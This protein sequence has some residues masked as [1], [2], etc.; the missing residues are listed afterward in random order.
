MFECGES[1]LSFNRCL[2]QG[3]VSKLPHYGRRSPCSCWLTCKK[4]GQG[5]EWASFVTWERKEHIR[6]AISCDNFWIMSRKSLGTDVAG[7]ELLC[8]DLPHRV[9]E[10]KK[11]R[12]L[13]AVFEVMA[14]L[15]GDVE[16]LE[17][18]D[19]DTPMEHVSKQIKVGTDRDGI[20][21]GSPNKIDDL[22]KSTTEDPLGRLE[23]KRR[24]VTV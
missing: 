2:R 18:V 24:L 15:A 8:S 19:D 9:E 4:V 20:F 6:Y 13:K 14:N 22:S 16:A 3:R 10:V 23:M 5:K 12:E 7:Q 21:I 1:N 11:K 17:D